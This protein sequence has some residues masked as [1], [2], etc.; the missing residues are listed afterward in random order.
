MRAIL[1]FGV[2]L[3]ITPTFTQD[4]KPNILAA[5]LLPGEG[6]TDPKDK[7]GYFPNTTGGVDALDLA[8]GK[9]LWSSKDGNRPLLATDTRLFVQAGKTNSVRVYVLNT[10]EKGKRVLE[11]LPIKFP[12]WVSVETAYGRRY[13]SH[14]LLDGKCFRLLWNANAFYSGGAAPPPKVQEAERK[15]A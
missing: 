6:V 12:S 14:G 2:I 4:E 15:S 10:T 9:L 3:G 11:S 8:T 13:S 5:R 1:L 7:V